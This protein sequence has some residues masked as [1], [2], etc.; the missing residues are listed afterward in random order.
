MI[1]KS[2]IYIPKEEKKK[3]KPLKL[4]LLINIYNQGNLV[5]FIPCL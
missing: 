1:L 5:T 2:L 4:N 3:K